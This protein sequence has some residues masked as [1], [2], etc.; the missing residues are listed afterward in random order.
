MGTGRNG[1][2]VSD[3]MLDPSS[4]RFNLGEMSKTVVFT[5]TQDSEDDDGESVGLAFGTLPGGVSGGG[6]T[7]ATV[8]IDDDD[9]PRVSVRFGSDSYSVSE[10]STTTVRVMLS[11]DPER[12]VTIDLV[13][14]NLG[15]VSDSDYS[16]VPQSLIFDRGVAERSFVFTAVRDLVSDAGEWVELTFTTLLPPGVDP[17]ATTT[18]TVRITDVSAQGNTPSVS[19][20]TGAYR[21]PEGATTTVGVRLSVAPGSD[22]TIPITATPMGGA[23]S[24]DYSGVPASVTYG[25][26]DTEASFTFVATQDSEDDDG[27]SVVLGFGNLIGGIR[28]GG[29]R[30]DDD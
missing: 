16:G 25:S 1:A 12:S 11:A 28:P 19:F 5:A 20:V 4:V 22:V 3:F 8:S 2:T 27:E 24:T 14:T 13:K 7:A 23:T 15:G 17:G 29:P 6:T 18:A 21:L 9:D 10:G 30:H 26:S